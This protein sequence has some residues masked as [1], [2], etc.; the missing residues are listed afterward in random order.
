MQDRLDQEI[1]TFDGR[2]FANWL[3]AGIP[4]Y[5]GSK[6]PLPGQRVPDAFPYARAYIGRN[7]ADLAADLADIHRELP[8]VTR[9][10]MERGILQ[11]WAENEFRD[12]AQFDIGRTLLV[13]ACRLRVK[14]LVGV[15][16]DALTLLGIA[17]DGAAA[18]PAANQARQLRRQAFQAAVEL[19]SGT[20][21]SIRSL[22]YFMEDTSIDDPLLAQGQALE[23]VRYLALT[24]PNRL[25][26]WAAIFGQ[27]IV[28]D[29]RLARG[30]ARDMRAVLEKAYG[31][32]Q[33]QV[34]I[35][36]VRIDHVM[37]IATEAGALS[38]SSMK[39]LYDIV[40]VLHAG[41]EGA[42]EAEA[43]EIPTM[44]WETRAITKTA[45]VVQISQYFKA[46]VRG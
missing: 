11:L 37:R 19:A 43:S 24:A 20:S 2:D 41:R 26:Y 36:M 32:E 9:V 16:P 21:E 28:R 44:S 1:F 4:T 30:K 38:P 10:A 14:A 5:C 8:A 39:G 40:P 33:V 46:E 27:A 23:I 3:K 7:E 25:A 13:L 6:A 45:T 35:D 18:P 12:A 34:L 15:L 22:E 29:H 31:V 17:H 42:S